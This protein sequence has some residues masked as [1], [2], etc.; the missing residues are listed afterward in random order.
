MIQRENISEEM[1]GKMSK[2]EDAFEK[3]LRFAEEKHK[4]QKRKDAPTQRQ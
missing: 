2:K 4:G 1:S 3:A